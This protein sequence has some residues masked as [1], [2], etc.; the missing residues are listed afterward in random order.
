MGTIITANP[1]RRPLTPVPGKTVVGR[2][3]LHLEA[4]SGLDDVSQTR[5][6]GAEA[7]ADLTRSDGYDTVRL[8][9]DGAAMQMDAVKDRN[10]SSNGPA[11]TSSSYTTSLVRKAIGMSDDKASGRLRISWC[12]RTSGRTR[13]GRG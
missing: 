6:G 7:V 12:H 8:E 10:Y 9:T 1:E 13:G 11:C 2:R 4:M 5:V 3:Y